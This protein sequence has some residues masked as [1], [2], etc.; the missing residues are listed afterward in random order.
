ML[1]V[2]KR[3]YANFPATKI[4]LLPLLIADISISTISATL[5]LML[6]HFVA[7]MCPKALSS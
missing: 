2:L 5:V 7:S 4:A 6:L 3:I 1:T